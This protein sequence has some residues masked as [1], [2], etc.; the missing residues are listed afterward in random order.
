MENLISQ[1]RDDWSRLAEELEKLRAVALEGRVT[2]ESGM[3]REATTFFEHIANEVYPDGKVPDRDREEMK[4]LMEALIETMQGTI[5]SIDFW[6][7]PDKQKRLRS[8]LKRALM[9]SKIEAL[10]EK[11]ERVAVEVMRLAK[12]RHTELL[13]GASESR[14]S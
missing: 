11:R 4:A 8:E 3:S 12:N 1:H 2:G 5:G 6:N 13:K 10:K 14:L 7:N 9:L